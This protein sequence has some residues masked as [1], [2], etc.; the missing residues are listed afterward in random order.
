MDQHG[1][2]ERPARAR[3]LIPRAHGSA[4][5]CIEHGDLQRDL[6]GVPALGGLHRDVDA[7]RL[8][9]LQSL[10][11]GSEE[12]DVP[13]AAEDVV[14]HGAVER[15]L[16]REQLAEER[17]GTVTDG[18][19]GPLV[20]SRPVSA[21]E[22]VR[23]ALRHQA[24]RLVP[25]HGHHECSVG[26]LGR[27]GDLRGLRPRGGPGL[28][29]PHEIIA[30]AHGV[31]FRVARAQSLRKRDAGERDEVVR[32]GVPRMTFRGT[33]TDGRVGWSSAHLK[34]QEVGT[35]ILDAYPRH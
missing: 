31:R 8:A 21:A 14:P 30:D 12:L 3:R 32:L 10:H 13:G 6:R 11:G 9:A 4:E 33:T 15:G 20:V 16:A 27:G 34:L 26:E 7:D 5:V 29:Q 24:S 35:R 19:T 22:Q 23:G 17:G 1:D 25:R 18:H 2:A 28:G